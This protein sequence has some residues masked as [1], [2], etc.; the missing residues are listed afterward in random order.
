MIATGQ[1]QDSTTI[2]LSHRFT[3][4]RSR[5]FRAW[6]DPKALQRWFA[7][8]PAHSLRTAEVDLR[9]GGQYRIGMGASRD[10][11]AYVTGVF[12]EVKPPERLVYTWLW[13]GVPPEEGE[14]LV[15][16][17]FHD[18]GNATEVVLTHSRFHDRKALTNH[19]EGWSGCFDG[20]AAYL[21]G[22]EEA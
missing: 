7:P 9:V 6:T 20:L 3:A 19:R 17:E 18:R 13:E 14:T 5:V 4:A 21:V 22:E 1:P 10:D 2:R 15:M 12:Q 16:V 11:M 8:N